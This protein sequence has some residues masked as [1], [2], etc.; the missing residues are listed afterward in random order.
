MVVELNSYN[1]KLTELRVKSNAIH[2]ENMSNNKLY[3]KIKIKEN[4]RLLD[5]SIS[6]F[7]FNFY[8]RNKIL[9]YKLKNY[10]KLILNIF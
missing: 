6:N 7:D 3:K 2:E 1:F 9:I 8:E 10:L 5:F 4:I